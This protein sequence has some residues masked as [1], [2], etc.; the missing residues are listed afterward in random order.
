MKKCIIVA[1]AD[2]GAIGKDG[3]IPWHLSEDLQY[4][5]RTT[6]GCPV[7]MGRRTFE[8]IGRPLPGRLNIV[9]HGPGS[10]VEG[11]FGAS[12]FEDAYGL[13]EMTGAEKCFVIG[14]GTVY[15]KAME[16]AD[17]LY[18]THVHAEI[19]DADAWFPKIN[20]DIWA[21]KS[22]SGEKEAP[23]GL[24]YEFVVYERAVRK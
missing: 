10:T 17:E 2:N 3:Q 7:I 14:G 21:R 22:E 9:L 13:A 5:K 1:V 12:C 8:S 24:R 15:A 23:D 16:E 19:P 6:M 18:V 4:F 20:A 11:A